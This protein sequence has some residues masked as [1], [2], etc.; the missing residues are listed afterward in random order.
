MFNQPEFLLFIKLLIAHLLT[1]FIFQRKN[2]VIDKQKKKYKSGK[3][4]LHVAITAIIAY[5]FCGQWQI[6]WLPFYIFI[7]HLLIDIWKA[8]QKQETIYFVLDQIFHVLALIILA[9]LW[10]NRWSEVF[11][12]INL[13]FNNSRFLLIT[14]GYLTVT[15]P[16]G[17]FIGQLTQKWQQESKTKVNGLSGAGIWIGLLERF[18]IFTFVLMQQYTAIGF[19]IAAKSILRYNDKDFNTQKQTEY[20]LIGTLISFASAIFLGLIVKSLF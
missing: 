14:A 17:I 6:W 12:F 20:V 4:Y 11:E 19:L 10:G 15:Y 2:W 5:L 1:D 3:L 7:T 16:F 9:V 18:L 8:Y 13:V